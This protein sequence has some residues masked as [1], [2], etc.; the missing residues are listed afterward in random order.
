[1]LSTFRIMS[2]KLCAYIPSEVHHV[3]GRAIQVQR[4]QEAAD[5]Q[6]DAAAPSQLIQHYLTATATET[7][8]YTN[9]TI[10]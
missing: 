2:Y 4:Q 7:Y 9:T 6:I 5:P 3:R 10:T 1:M 8:T